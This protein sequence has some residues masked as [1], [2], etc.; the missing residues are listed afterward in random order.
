MTL[1]VTLVLLLFKDGKKQHR[2][3]I[4]LLEKLKGVGRPWNTSG[5][6]MVND[7][8]VSQ[9]PRNRFCSSVHLRNHPSVNQPKGQHRRWHP[10][11]LWWAAEDF[12][13]SQERAAHGAGGQLWPQTQSKVL[14]SY[15]FPVGGVPPGPLH[16]ERSNSSSGGRGLH[17]SLNVTT[18]LWTPVF[19]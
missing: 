10:L 18:V 4:L 17:R 7:S 11:H 1:K 14:L 12:K 8:P 3:G 6:M 19:I 5:L 16:S 2:K 13:C 15:R 9:T